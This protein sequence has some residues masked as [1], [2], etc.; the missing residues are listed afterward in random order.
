MDPLDNFWKYFI[1][2]N[3]SI[4]IIFACFLIIKVNS[5][6][7]FLCTLEIGTLLSSL[8]FI[9]IDKIVDKYDDFNE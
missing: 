4:G 8:A 5:V 1:Q 9:M 2:V 7:S 6:P 3:L